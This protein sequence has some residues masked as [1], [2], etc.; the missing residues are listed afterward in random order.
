MKVEENE[1]SAAK[2]LHFTERS[3]YFLPSPTEV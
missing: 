1:I 3:N 2:I